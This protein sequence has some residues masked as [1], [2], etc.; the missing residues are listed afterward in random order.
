VK[1]RLFRRCRKRGQKR[2]THDGDCRWGLVFDGAK[3]DG[4]RKQVLRSF[5]GDADQAESWRR[6]L[7]EQVRDGVEIAPH[8]RTLQQWLDEWIDK[9]IKPP[10]AAQATYARYRGLVD[11]HI[12]P[13][14]G[15]IRL[16]NLKSL[17]VSDYYA[18]LTVA[19]ATLQLHHTVLTSALKAAVKEGLVARNVAALATKSKASRSQADV[20]DHVWTAEEAARFLKAAKDAGPQL[21]GLFALALDSGMRRGEIGG[22]Q[23]ADVDWAEGS[24][25]VQRSLLSRGR[26][27]EYG[28]PKTKSG[29]RAIDL[30]PETMALLKTH[31]QHQ[32]ELKMR[33]RAAYR[34][35]G[36]V[37][38]KE[39][40]DLHGRED[41]LGAP[42]AMHN[43]GD[44]EMRRIVKAAGVRRIKFHGLRHTMATL[45][46]SASVPPQVVQR[47]LGHSKIEMT[48]GIY[49]HVLPGQQAD[50]AAKLAVLLHR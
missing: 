45:M 22:L 24:I 26:E 9:A 7:L 28:L 33:N 27:P 46:L 37:F 6:K 2:C 19:P 42:L 31:K 41:S 20:L 35:H 49:S 11:H 17:D 1:G 15:S 29:I 4:K 36:L 21:A 50:A 48:L 23:W 34:D 39:W 16:Q 8:E 32:A 40:G 18:G 25:R 38:A 10:K 12:A 14:L 13:K 47:R 5:R 43:L 30:S 3:V 44:R